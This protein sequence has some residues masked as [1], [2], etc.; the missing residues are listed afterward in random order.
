MPHLEAPREHSYTRSE[1]VANT[2]SAGAGLVVFLGV[3][4]FLMLAALRSEQP[5]AVASAAI[6]LASVLTPLSHFD[7]LSRP[8]AWEG[9]TCSSPSRSCGDLRA[10]CR[11]V[12]A[13]CTG[14]SRRKRRRNPRSRRVGDGR[15]GNRVQARRRDPIQAA[16]E[17]H[18]SVHGVVGNSLDSAIHRERHLAGLSLGPR[19][20]SRLYRGHPL[21]RRRRTEPT[22]TSSGISLFSRDPRATPSPYGDMRFEALGI[23]STV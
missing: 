6:F 4:P 2:V 21:L 3:S 12:H 11:N 17:R 13:L 23:H 22:C 5:W 14:S 1:E 18:L 19:R 7:A 8:G 10:D 15:D 16:V 9:E 20:R